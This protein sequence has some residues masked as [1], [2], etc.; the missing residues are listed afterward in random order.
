MV[1][2]WEAPSFENDEQRNVVLTDSEGSGFIFGT[3][4]TVVPVVLERILT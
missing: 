3:D 2:R 4:I 1:T